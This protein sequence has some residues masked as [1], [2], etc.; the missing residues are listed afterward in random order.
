[1]KLWASDRTGASERRLDVRS[2]RFGFDLT[3]FLYLG[4]ITAQQSEAIDS[5]HNRPHCVLTVARTDAGAY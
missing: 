3:S 2:A 1:M 5:S 4:C